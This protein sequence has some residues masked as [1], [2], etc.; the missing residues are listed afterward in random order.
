MASNAR[1]YGRVTYL[2]AGL[3]LLVSASSRLWGQT[4]VAGPNL[5][6]SSEPQVIPLWDGPAPGALGD[7]PADRPIVTMYRPATGCSA[8][9]VPQTAVIV[10]PGGGYA[11]LALNHEG[12]QE[13][14]WFSSLGV[15]SF[16]LE[17]R[18]GP[19]YH[20][21]IELGDA[22]RA[23]RLVRYR[24]KEFNVNA[25]RV[26]IMGFS[27]GG[28][29]AATV[30][31]HF[32][33][34]NAAAKDPFDRESSRPD[35]LILGYPVISMRRPIT[36]TGS[37]RNLLGDSPDQELVNEL[38]NELHVTP[39]T[40]PTF[41]VH[42]T[43]DA[44][45]PVENSIEFYTALRRANV[46]VEMHLFENGPHGFGMALFDPSLRTWTTLLTNWMSARG[47]LAPA[48]KR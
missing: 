15:T 42:G 25:D 22:Q 23:V 39:Q 1:C 36:H 35:F 4:P 33:S 24:A 46:P 10:A 48:S 18:L 13:A 37:L 31:T 34:G 45:V 28:H 47:L 29:L 5:P 27:A 16:V 12:V 40:P 44:A 8:C 21:P 2:F 41:I 19:R 38:S 26:G 11:R 20:H 30:A 32:D 6:L 17:Y 3:V 7:G 9:P 14:Y 43:N